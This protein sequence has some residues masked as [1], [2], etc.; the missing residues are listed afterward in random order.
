[1]LPSKQFDADGYDIKLR[2]DVL[3]GIPSEFD[4][5]NINYDARL[6][7]TLTVDEILN[8]PFLWGLEDI[9][10]DSKPY[11]I[12]IILNMKVE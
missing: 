2:K 1:M 11:S 5:S 7:D 8:D 6:A 3:L 10:N 4:L 12:S 9:S